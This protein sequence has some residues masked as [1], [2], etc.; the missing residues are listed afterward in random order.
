M[1]TPDADRNLLFGLLALQN[2][3]IDQSKLV[4][5]F[6]AWTLDKDRPLADHLVARGD[7]EPNQRAV[8]EAMVGLHLKKHG[9][10]TEQSLAAIPTGR[11]TRESLARLADPEMKASLARLGPGLP[12]LHEHAGTDAPT[13]DAT[14]PL[15]DDLTLD[16]GAEGVSVLSG[17]APQVGTISRI[18]LLDADSGADPPIV[19]NGEDDGVGSAGRYRLLGEIA[20]GGMGAVLKGRDPDLRRDLA[21]KILLHRHR[22]RPDLIQRFVEEAQICGQLQHPGVVPVYEL[23][24]LADHRPFFTMK[25]VKGRTLASLLDARQSPTDDLPRFLGIFEQVCQTVAYAHARGVIHRDLK[26]SNVM[27]GAFGEV[28]VMDWGLAKVL[29]K[30]AEDEE[31]SRPA[32]NETVVA[33]DRRRGDINLSQA[34]SVLGTPAYMAPEQARGETESMD[35]RAD[36]FALGSILCEILTGQPAFTGLSAVE[37]L[38]NAGRADTANALDRLARCMADPELLALARNCLATEPNDRPAD[39]GVVANRM[40][41]YLAGV[42]ERLRAAELARAAERARAEEAHRTAEEAEAKAS[43]ERRA[44][45]LKVRWPRPSSWL[46]AWERPAGGGSSWSGSTGRGN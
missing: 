9:G 35:R 46:A 3:L 34:G 28:Q 15:G 42:Q 1:P 45:R 6:Q 17:I 39:A 16:P 43:A 14:P 18:A 10:S 21:L 29:P 5:A 4:A 44:R 32:K 12:R 7:L 11:S 30:S 36:A 23:G 20:R 41:A 33:T 37:I 40:T 19:E 13:V 2:G 27:V 31:A 22:D 38:H 26:P 25:L 24:A 8:V